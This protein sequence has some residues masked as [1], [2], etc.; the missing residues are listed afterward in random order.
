MRQLIAGH[1]PD[2]GSEV[3]VT[4]VEVTA[5]LKKRGEV[6]IFILGKPNNFLTIGPLPL[7]TPPRPVGGSL[8]GP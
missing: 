4:D 3:K 5:A 8:C 2:V 7:L 1:I 6:E